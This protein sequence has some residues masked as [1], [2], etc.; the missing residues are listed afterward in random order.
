[1]EKDNGSLCVV[2]ERNL[3]W[4]QVVP[5]APIEE[6]ASPCVTTHSTKPFLECSFQTLKWCT[7]GANVTSCPFILL[8]AHQWCR[9]LPLFDFTALNS[10]QNSVTRQKNCNLRV[11]WQCQYLSALLRAKKTWWIDQP[12]KQ[13]PHPTVMILMEDLLKTLT[14]IEAQQLTTLQQ[15]RST[16]SPILPRWY[17]VLLL[18]L[19][20]M[21]P[22]SVLQVLLSFRESSEGRIATKLIWH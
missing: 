10:L 14:R 20:G 7:A 18:S 21:S 12:N 16:M 19:M 3:A 8:Q 6:I 2:L 9:H 1:M 13:R 5:S 4:S 17:S 15:L 11:I 22:L